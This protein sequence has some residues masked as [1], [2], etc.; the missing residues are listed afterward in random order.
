[1]TIDEFARNPDPYRGVARVDTP[2][3][4]K[5]LHDDVVQPVADA[6]AMFYR[7]P[8]LTRLYSTMS[9]DEMT[10][11]PAFN[12]NVDLAQVSNVH[13][14]RQFIECS[15]T[16]NQR[17]APWRVKLPQGGV[18]VGKGTGDWP[19]AAGSMP[20]NLKIVSLSTRGPGTVVKD[21][22][23][24]IGM[25]LFKTA[26]TTGQRHRNA[27]STAERRDDRRTQETV[28]PPT[29]PA[30][31]PHAQD[32]TAATPGSLKPSGS[33]RCSVSRAGAGAGSALALVVPARGCDPRAL[34]V[35]G[36]SR[37]R[38]CAT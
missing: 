37:G 9:A 21:N 4:F 36:P 16:L 11:D 19:A 13:I 17:E 25:T 38:A 15:P 35:G 31:A 2:K 14:A 12:Y 20:A 23:E 22:S 7:A 24:D 5:L 26:G 1:M 30:R 8:Y 34:D 6:A 29:P 10:V 32:P 27:P 18:I 28:T 33:S 3:F